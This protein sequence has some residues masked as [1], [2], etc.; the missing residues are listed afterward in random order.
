MNFSK[1][2]SMTGCADCVGFRND[3]C[4]RLCPNGRAIDQDFIWLESDDEDD[5]VEHDLVIEGEIK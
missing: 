1:V 5:D 2:A 3:L 4:K